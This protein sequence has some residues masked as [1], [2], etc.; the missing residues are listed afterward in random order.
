ME[1][2]DP[3]ARTDERSRIDPEG[4]VTPVGPMSGSPGARQQ[5]EEST[6]AAGRLGDGERSASA[7]DGSATTHEAM[8]STA[9]PSGSETRAAGT[10]PEYRST[11]AEACEEPTAPPEAA[12]G[13]VGPVVRPKSPPV[14]P[15]AAVEEEDV[16]E[17]IIHAEPQ[18]QSVRIFRK[19]DDKVVV[20]EEKD[21]PRR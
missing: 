13:M 4:E 5:A 16:V 8:A 18:T 14:V 11:E 1:G 3:S 10:A 15:P 6:T 2:L 19:H 21:T 17:E 9:R 20:V 7:K 12:P